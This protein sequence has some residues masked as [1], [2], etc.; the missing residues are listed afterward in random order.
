MVKKSWEKLGRKLTKQPPKRV[1]EV[2]RK[3]PK[4]LQ[5]KSSVKQAGEKISPITPIDWPSHQVISWLGL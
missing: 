4:P 3:E 2:A 5:A 1:K